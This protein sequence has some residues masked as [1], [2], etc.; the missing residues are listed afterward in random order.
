M[1]INVNTFNQ[2]SDKYLLYR[3][4]YP[5]ELYE[6]IKS[7]T[8]NHN[9]VWDCACGNGQISIDISE[10]FTLVEGSDIN[11]NQIL[12]A[13]KRKN[14]NY[15]VQNSESTNYMNDYFDVVCVGQ[16]LHWFCSDKFFDEVKRVLKKDGFFFCWGYSFF[17]ISNELDEIIEKEFFKVIDSFWSDKNRVLHDKYSN[18]DF[19]FEKIEI[20]VIKMIEHWN[21]N[22]LMAYLNTWSA[23]KICN[24]KN[25]IDIVDLLENKLVNYWNESEIKKIEMEFFVY[26]GKNNT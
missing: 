14:I 4:K 5:K 26:G 19:P 7:V 18:I 15:S 17:K 8:R 2:E 24:E 6:L 12:N 13:T 16:A 21:L 23:V 11:E 1:D 9:T 20:P 22:Q 3:P 25:N 10:Y